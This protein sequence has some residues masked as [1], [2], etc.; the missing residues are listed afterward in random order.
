MKT[1]ITSIKGDGSITLKVSGHELEIINEA[2]EG[3][4]FQ[5]P[6]NEL[7][8]LNVLQNLK[9]ALHD[10]WEAE[11]VQNIA[12]IAARNVD[13][14]TKIAAHPLNN[15]APADPIEAPEIDPE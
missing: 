11:Y 1:K 13:V 8:R 12:A 4:K 14:L 15:V 3:A 9:T 2:I 5:A 7:T 6:E 10:L